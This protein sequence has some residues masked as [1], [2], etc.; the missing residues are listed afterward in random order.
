MIV[1]AGLFLDLA[2]HVDAG[3]DA[4]AFGGKRLGGTFDG[5][6]QSVVDQAF[7]IDGAHVCSP[8]RIKRPS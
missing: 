3:E 5:V 6:V 8:E 2:V 4:E 7:E 1:L